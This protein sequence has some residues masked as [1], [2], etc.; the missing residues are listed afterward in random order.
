MT[1]PAL[2]SRPAARAKAQRFIPSGGMSDGPRP[3]MRPH[4]KALERLTQQGCQLHSLSSCFV[5][6]PWVISV[7]SGGRFGGAKP[8]PFWLGSG[9]CGR[10]RSGPGD[11]SHPHLDLVAT[12][13]VPGAVL[14][15]RLPVHADGIRKGWGL[16]LGVLW[17]P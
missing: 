12:E 14:L 11:P 6:Q 13:H 5:P 10:S 1:K 9:Y 17:D 15:L 16:H 4:L 2:P 8:S 7:L 3:A